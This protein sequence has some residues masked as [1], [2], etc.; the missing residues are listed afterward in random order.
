MEYSK[1]TPLCAQEVYSLK[2][3]GASVYG[4]DDSKV[5]DVSHVRPTG[6]QA[7][8]IIKVGGYKGFGTKAVALKLAELNFMRSTDGDIIAVT[9]RTGS[10]LKHLPLYQE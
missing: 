9:P 10:E 3:E 5:G 7:Q 8:V 4:P 2:I 6:Q 1:Y